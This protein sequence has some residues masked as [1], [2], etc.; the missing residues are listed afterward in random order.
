MTMREVTECPDPDTRVF[1]T[2]APGA[3]G[4]EAPVGA[5]RLCRPILD[6][7]PVPF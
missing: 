1:S 2:Y 7:V 6:S 3:D 5:I 4:K